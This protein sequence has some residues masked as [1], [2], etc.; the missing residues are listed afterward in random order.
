AM[1]AAEVDTAVASCGTAFGSEHLAMLRRF[2][3]DDRYFRGEIIYTFDGDE[4]GQKAALRAFEGDQQFT[5]RSYVTVAPGGQDPCDIRLER[6]DEAVR[7]LVSHRI[8]MFEF[9]IRTLL[10]GYDTA[11]VDGRVHAMRR[12]IP[13]LAGIKDDALRDEYSRQAAGWVGFDDPDDIVAQVREEARR[14]RVE[15]PKLELKRGA[16]RR[17]RL[18]EEGT[19]AGQGAA[20]QGGVPGGEDSGGHLRVVAGKE[21]P[22]SKDEFLLGIREALK[23][24]LQVP[25]LAGQIFDLMLLE[26]FVHPTYIAIVIA[27]AAAGRAAWASTGSGWRNAV[28]LIVSDAVGPAVALEHAVGD[29]QCEQERLP[30]Y[31]SAFMARMQHR[32]VSNDVVELPAEMQRMRPD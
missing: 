30:Q 7:E 20:N 14:G 8:P 3:L 31:A 26:S 23:L 5:G 11:A 12:I 6:G 13:V 28:G 18:A 16:A 21:R 27:V 2:M 19:P 15:K 17:E 1:H 32:W 24:G 29:M 10:E 9:V 22:D 4:A 25:E